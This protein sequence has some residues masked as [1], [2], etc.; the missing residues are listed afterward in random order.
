MTRTKVSVTVVQ[1]QLEIAG[2]DTFRTIAS[3][4]DGFNLNWFVPG[5]S[6]AGFQYADANTTVNLAIA[7]A[8]PAGIVAGFFDDFVNGN[9]VTPATIPAGQTGS[10]TP[11]FVGQPTA[12]NGTYFVTASIP[13]VTTSTSDLQTVVSAVPDLTFSTTD[14]VIGVG[15]TTAND[16]Q[17]AIYATVLG[18]AFYGASPIDVTLTN[19][20]PT[21]ATAPDVVTISAG[22]FS[23]AFSIAGLQF[24]NLTVAMWP[25]VAPPLNV[26][27]VNPVLEFQFDAAPPTLAV[28]QLLDFFINV[29]VPPGIRTG[30]HR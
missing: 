9:A 8:V 17:L 18:Y 10:R 6:I 28:G 3:A 29:V 22:D 4:G 30:K 20:D 14:A 16:G 27:V 1:P 12:T 19:S 23:S 11:V 21:L 15:M 25:T 13:G 2:L 26:Q 24:G 7:S 5:N